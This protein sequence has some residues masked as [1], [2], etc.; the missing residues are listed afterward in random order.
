MAYLRFLEDAQMVVALNAG[1]SHWELNLPVSEHLPDGTVLVDL[2]GGGEAV[3]EEGHL[4]SRTLLP[5]EGAVFKP[6]DP[7]NV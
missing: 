1:S 3:V 6:N 5:W 4:R 7:L 2:L